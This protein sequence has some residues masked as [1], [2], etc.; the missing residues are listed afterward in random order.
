VS[1]RH[2]NL[3]KYQNP[4]PLQRWLIAR[5]LSTVTGLVE[6]LRSRQVL[7]VGC[8]EGF[9]SAHLAQ[10]FREGV[11][12]AG[13]DVDQASLLR[14]RRLLP[15]MHRGVGDAQRLPFPDDRFDLVIC[16]EVLEHLD[17]PEVALRE[18]KRVAC[19]HLLLSVPHEPWFRTM[20]AMRGKHLREWGN[21][22]EHVQQ[23]T[24][25]QFAEFVGQELRVERRAS[26]LPWTILLCRKDNVA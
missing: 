13:V 21:D 14:G 4:N 23:W 1:K 9:V 19:S 11:L 25:R 24:A 20:N 3:Q 18:L 16:N 26:S 17:S 2:G 10:G 12:F 7:D 5:F 22:P 15:P 6:G 8:A